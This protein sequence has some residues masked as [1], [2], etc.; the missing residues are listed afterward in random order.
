MGNHWNEIHRSWSRLVPP[1]RPNGEVVAAIRA[2][3]RP[4]ADKVLILG[5]TPEFADLGDDV[6]AIDINPAMIAHVWP[7][8]ASHRRIVR[9][10]WL[11]LPCASATRTVAIGDGS[12]TVLPFPDGYTTLFGELTS[13]LG[14]AGRAIFRLYAT[15]SPGEALED[16]QAATMG[17][18]IGSIHAL[19]WRLAMAC[20][21]RQGHPNVA[22]RDILNAFTELFPNRRDLARNT[23]WSEDDIAIIDLYRTSDVV[24]SFPTVER[25]L[26]TT[27]GYFGD[28]HLIEM[29]TYEMAERCPLLVLDRAAATD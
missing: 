7:G 14:P 17:G 13:V 9:G 15:P 25:V 8:N 10:N 21:A 4:D 1:L 11:R 2:R 3:L 28:T 5:A 22:V 19:K 29:G 27:V 12:L 24:F 6:L 23:G 26:Q 20:V 18:R 16:V